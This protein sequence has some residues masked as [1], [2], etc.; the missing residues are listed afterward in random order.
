[1]VSIRLPF[2]ETRVQNTLKVAALTLMLVDHVHL[3][4]FHRSLVWLYWLTRLVLPM[5]MLIAAQNLERYHARPLKYL[6]QLVGFGVLAQP[7]YFM[8]FGFAQL[9]IMFTIAAGVAVY[10]L[11]AWSK[12]R[13]HW[14]LRLLAMAGLIFIPFPLEAGWAGVIA[15]PVFAALMRRGAWWDWLLALVIS[16]TIVA[17]TAPWFVT[18]A[19]LP[20]WLLAAQIPAK[21]TQAKSQKPARWTQW[22]SYGF[23]P[24]HLTV[25]ALIS[26]MG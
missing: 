20:I 24:L 19:A 7:F 4:F 8:V 22:A 11:L 5:F 23:Y 14:S 17:G 13:L 3:V 12:T 9:N 1:M 26:R 18:V 21:F 6:A 25:I 2:I 16:L 10:A 15:V